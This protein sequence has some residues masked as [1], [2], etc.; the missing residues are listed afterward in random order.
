MFVEQNLHAKFEVKFMMKYGKV[1]EKK[2][3]CAERCRNIYIL[4]SSARYIE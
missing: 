1:S 4:E 2:T 3:V